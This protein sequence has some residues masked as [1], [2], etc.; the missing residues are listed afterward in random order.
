MQQIKTVHYSVHNSPHYSLYCATI[1]QYMQSH[2]NLFFGKKCGNATIGVHVWRQA[3][4]TGKCCQLF[5]VYARRH[6][7]KASKLHVF[8]IMAYRST[9]EQTVQQKLLIHITDSFKGAPELSVVHCHLQGRWQTLSSPPDALIYATPR[10]TAVNKC[11]VCLQIS[12]HTMVTSIWELNCNHMDWHQEEGVCVC[13]C[14]CVCA[15]AC[16]L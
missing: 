14:V 1:I 6:W 16:V 4:C 12:S 3:V 5:G 10:W 2:G 7:Q 15:R 9:T 11:P 8:W 13:A